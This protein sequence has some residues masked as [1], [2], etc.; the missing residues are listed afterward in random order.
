MV[1]QSL[2]PLFHCNVPLIWCKYSPKRIVN[3]LN[4]TVWIDCKE[5]IPEVPMVAFRK[6]ENL[7]QYLVRAR[8]TEAPKEKAAGTSNCSSKSCQIC[9]YFYV[10]NTFCNKRNGKEL[11][12]N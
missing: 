2:N 7:A 12:I 11:K 6:P 1:P 4:L 9:N 5:A 10:G 3:G 8:F